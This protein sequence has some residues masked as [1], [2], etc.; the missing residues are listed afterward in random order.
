MK[1]SQ[2][3]LK[4]FIEEKLRKDDYKSDSLVIKSLLSAI[5][6]EEGE[7]SEERESRSVKLVEDTDGKFTAESLKLYNL[8]SVSY[9]DLF[10]FLKDEMIILAGIPENTG[11]KIALSVLNLLYEF[12]PKMTRK[13]NETDAKIIMAVYLQNKQ[14]FSIDQLKATYQ[15]QFKVPLSKEQAVR[16]LSFLNKHRVVEQ[17]ADGTF[18]GKE[19]VHYE[20]N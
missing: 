18:I 14:P 19:E 2:K 13:F 6:L 20:R 9:Y 7:S 4:T 15:E 17:K 5:V 12:V 16:S 3:I 8:M 11:L 1:D 10:G